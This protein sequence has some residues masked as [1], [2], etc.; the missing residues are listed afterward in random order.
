[1]AVG[2][3]CNASACMTC[4]FAR[5]QPCEWATLSKSLC[6]SDSVTY[7]TDSPW[8]APARANCRPK[9][10]LPVPEVPSIRD[11]PP[12]LRPPRRMSSSP[13]MPVSI[14]LMSSFLPP[15]VSFF[16][17]IILPDIGRYLPQ[18]PT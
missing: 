14:S 12:G 4:T 5:S 13:A 8:V 2:L 6:V 15:A 10:V 1:M 3:V 18:C 16:G 11:S 9:V 7:S 17:M